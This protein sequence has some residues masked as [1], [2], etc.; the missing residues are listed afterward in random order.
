MSI[1]IRIMITV[2]GVGHTEKGERRKKWG[3]SET[4]YPPELYCLSAAGEECLLD[5]F[6]VTSPRGDHCTFKNERTLALIS[7]ESLCE[8]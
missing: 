7:F 3:L 6:K 4:F 2:V 5:L 1:V 8:N